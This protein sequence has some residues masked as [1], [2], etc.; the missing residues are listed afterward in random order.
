[1]LNLISLDRTSVR[2]PI[3]IERSNVT[4]LNDPIASRYDGVADL[5][6]E[7][8]TAAPKDHSTGH[9]RACVH[10]AIVFLFKML[11]DEAICTEQILGFSSILPPTHDLAVVNLLPVLYQILVRVQNLKFPSRAGLEP[12][13]VLNSGRPKC[14]RSSTW[15]GVNRQSHSH[16]LNCPTNLLIRP[17]TMLS[18][19]SNMKSSPIDFSPRLTV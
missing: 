11:E 2:S 9:F 18:P 5:A 12:P 4:A 19:R 15:A 10:F 1:M 17:R 7:Y 6:I 8:A 14:P 13:S 16:P 3:T